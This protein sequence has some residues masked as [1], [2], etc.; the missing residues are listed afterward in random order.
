M[1]EPAIILGIV[2]LVKRHNEPRRRGLVH[3][4]LAIIL[5][6][7]GPLLMTVGLVALMA[8]R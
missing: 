3:A 6:V 2:G 4:W 7:C 1:A 8:S 5:G